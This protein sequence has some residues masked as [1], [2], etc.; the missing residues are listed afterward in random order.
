MAFIRDTLNVKIFIL[1]IFAVVAMTSIVIVAYNNITNVNLKYSEKAGELEQ[2]FEELTDVQ[3]TLNRT[4]EELTIKEVREGDLQDRY[5]TLKDD[6]DSLFNEKERLLKEMDA[7]NS[8][9]EGLLINIAGKE[10]EITDL[11]D[12]ISNWKDEVGC[13]R[14]KGDADEGSC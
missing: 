6:R 1:V 7:L 14:D 11:N 2:S 10:E 4:A 8:K 12:E 3:K 5:L 13:L 9:I